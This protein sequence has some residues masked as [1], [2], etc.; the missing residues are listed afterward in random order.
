MDNKV[1]LFQKWYDLR[2]SE[3]PVF[4]EEDRGFTVK[5]WYLKNSEELN[6]KGDA[7]FVIKHGNT[8]VRRFLYPA[9]KIFNIAAHFGDIVDGELSKDD[10]E[11]GYKIAGS[12]GLGGCV[13]PRKA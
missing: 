10:K 8:F 1:S 4:E 2:E 7:L 13:L 11:R 9:Y 5:C 12:D 3:T 6:V